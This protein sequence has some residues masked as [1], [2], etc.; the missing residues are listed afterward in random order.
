[1]ARLYFA[2]FNR[3][4]DLAGLEYWITQY[5]VGMG[6]NSISEAFALSPVILA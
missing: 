5:R 2:Y 6:L 4:P 1:M 3:I